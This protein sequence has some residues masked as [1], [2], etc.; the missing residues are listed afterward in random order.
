M[1]KDSIGTAEQDGRAVRIGFRTSI[2]TL[3]VAVLLLVGLTLVYL[4]FQ[5]VTSI[6]RTAAATFLARVAEHTADRIDAQFKDVHDSLEVLKQLPS[7]QSA[8]VADNPR[9]YALMA[10][11]L[12]SDEHLFNSYV[13]YDDGRFLQMDVI[14]RAGPLYRSK[15]AAPEQA[16]FRLVSI[17]P[18]QGTVAPTSKVTF[19]SDDLTALSQQPGPADYDPRGRPWYK[20]A[21]DPGA[22]ILTDPYIFFATGQAGYTL[23]AAIPQGRA[24]V[25]A[26]DVMLGEAE[27]LLQ[28]QQL[29][30]SGMAFL[31]DDADRVVAY[32]GLSKR[33]AAQSPGTAVVELPTLAEVD[34]IGVAG[35]IRA[36]RNGGAAGQLFDGSD[37]REYGAAF[38][39]IRTAGSANLRLV[40]L[41]PLEEFFGEIERERRA[42]FALTLAI[43]LGTLPLVFWI[44][45]LMSRRLRDLALETDRIQHFSPLDGPQLRS[46]IREIDDLGRSVHTLR[47]VVQTFSK[48]VPRRLVQRLVESRSAMT[49]GGTRR[50]ISVLFTDIA[51]FTAITENADPEQVMLYTSRYFAALSQ[52]IMATGGVVDKFIGDAVMA[53]WNAP[54]E[55]EDHVLKACGAVLDC[56]DA[57]RDLNRAFLREGWPAYETRFGLHVGEALVGNIGS[58]DRM[59]FSALGATVNL[60]SRLEGLNKNYGTAVLVSEAVRNVATAY[61]V[62]RRVDDISPKGFS[63]SFAIF[64][65]RCR[66]G[67]HTETEAAF[68]REWDRLFAAIASTPRAEALAGLEAFLDAYPDDEIAKYHQGRLRRTVPVVAVKAGR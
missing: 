6:T 42:L 1:S 39:S 18:G 64:E 38:Q 21:R 12:R 44:G 20:G 17:V 27:A 2:T 48:F 9:L 49:L 25:V 15:L 19:L 54:T 8:D 35:A 60:A 45:S 47:S 41:A 4:S 67:S 68:C 58:A 34:R 29:G 3:F 57:N 7:I 30:T 55:D 11:M 52:A 43:V 37:G 61:F 10:A 23:R 66:R 62:F 50:Q 56:L 22:G 36:W 31:F 16:R 14:D 26:G 51:D 63:E 33:V 46:V 59:N 53:I 40:V 5:R 65:L 28:R 13:G 32:P 24:G